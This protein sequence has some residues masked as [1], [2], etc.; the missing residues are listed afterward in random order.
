[1]ATASFLH[2]TS[3]KSSLSSLFRSDLHRRSP[4]VKCSR[5]MKMKVTMSV[6]NRSYWA[7]MEA[8]IKAHLKQAIPIHPPLSVTEPMDHLIFAAPRS[9]APALCIAACELVGG[10]R[11][12]A[13]AAA[14][15]LHLMHAALYTHE[16]LPLSKPKPKTKPTIYH[17]FKPN[18]ELLTGDGILPLGLELL[19]RS[20]EPT[21]KNS[22][23]ILRVIIEITRAVGSQGML[24]GL[25]LENKCSGSDGGDDLCDV[26]WMAHV[27]EKKVGEF[28][29]CGAACGAILGEG[30]EEEIEKLRKF[31]FYVGM[32]HGMVLFGRDSRYEDKKLLEVV[33]GF[34]VLALKELEGFKEKQILETILE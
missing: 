2:C 3:Q 33:E 34:R 15:A 7:V 31:G 22:G 8:D 30:S 6:D 16:H 25:Y 9:L 12:Q 32:I 28:Y 21:I 24:D 4:S 27:G 14:S 17:S 20:D 11:N 19:A 26:G 10:Q 13:I 1:M 29:A 23:R 18:I 5:P